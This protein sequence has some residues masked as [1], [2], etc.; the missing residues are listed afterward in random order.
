M[1]GA[2]AAPGFPFDAYEGPRAPA[3]YQPSAQLQVESKRFAPVAVAGWFSGERDGAFVFG[4]AT[5]IPAK[6]GTLTGVVTALGKPGVTLRWTQLS[7]DFQ[8][9]P[10]IAQFTPDAQQS[11]AIKQVAAPCLPGQ[12]HR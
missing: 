8:T 2:D 7:N 6:P 5:A 3:A 10:L 1:L 4:I 12:G 9:P 11:R